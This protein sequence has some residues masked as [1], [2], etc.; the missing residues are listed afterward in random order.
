MADV[1]K[2][3]HYGDLSLSPLI[4]IMYSPSLQSLHVLVFHFVFLYFAW[5]LSIFCLPS[6]G[7]WRTFKAR[8]CHALLCKMFRSVSHW[9]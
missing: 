9:V 3:Q 6:Y 5:V 7:V 4:S 8:M 1:H 2:F